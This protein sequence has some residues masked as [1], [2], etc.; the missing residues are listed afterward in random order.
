MEIFQYELREAVIFPHL[1]V[2]LSKMNCD[3]SAVVSEIV[4]KITG[5]TSAESGSKLLGGNAPMEPGDSVD[6][7]RRTHNSYVS[8]LQ[9]S[10]LHLFAPQKNWQEDLIAWDDR[11]GV[12]RDQI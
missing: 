10:C 2:I 11:G 12:L 5:K 4:K 9:V 7:Q 3:T 6:R 1:K 8:G